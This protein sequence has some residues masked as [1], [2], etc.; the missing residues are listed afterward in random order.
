M[1]ETEKAEE[2]KSKTRTDLHSQTARGFREKIDRLQQQKIE[3]EKTGTTI[4]T[5]SDKV[6]VKNHLPAIQELFEFAVGW[7]DQERHG[8]R[9]PQAR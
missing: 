9:V 1:A 2:K 6:R 4:L 3:L 5:D 8:R 7:M